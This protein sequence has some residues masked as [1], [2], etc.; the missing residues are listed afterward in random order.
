[1]VEQRFAINLRPDIFPSPIEK[2]QDV[3]SK[4]RYPS[5]GGQK[6]VFSISVEV[7]TM[8]KNRKNQFI[9]FAI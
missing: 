3:A 1:M 6:G 5:E 7:T 8:G 2:K 9:A 4:N